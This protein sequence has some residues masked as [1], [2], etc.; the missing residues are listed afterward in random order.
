[1]RTVIPVCRGMGIYNNS[2]GFPDIFG[3]VYF[4]LTFLTIMSDIDTITPYNI[5]KTSDG[6]KE[7][8]KLGDY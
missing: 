4:Q 5:K 1:M 2:S 7:K 3:D 8:Y 6:Y